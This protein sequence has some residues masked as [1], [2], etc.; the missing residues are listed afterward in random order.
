MATMNVWIPPELARFVRKKVASGLYSSA[1]EVVREALRRFALEASRRAAT[2]DE[3]FDRARV[4][5]AVDGLLRSRRRTTLGRGLTIHELR[6][7]G[8]K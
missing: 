4:R 5:K 3:R 7:H 1:S 2:G 6:S 8:R